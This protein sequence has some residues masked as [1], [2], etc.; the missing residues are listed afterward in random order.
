MKI[1]DFGDEFIEVLGIV[2]SQRIAKRAPRD[3]GRLAKSFAATMEISGNSIIWTLPF[4]WEFVE[5][6]TIHMP[7]NPFVRTT[8]EVDI[9]DIVEEVLL[10]LSKR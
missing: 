3:T 8:L 4:Y 1:E 10:I 2:L 6:G 5:Y 9:E 7:P